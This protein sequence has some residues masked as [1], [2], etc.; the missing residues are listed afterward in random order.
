MLNALRS[1]VERQIA[2]TRAAGGL[3]GLAGEGKPLP[4][5]DPTQ[6]TA[7]ATGLRIMADAGVVPEEIPL[8]KQLHEARQLYATLTDPVEKRAQSALIAD[9]ELRYNTAREARKKFMS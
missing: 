4:Y 6:N 2:K 1:L 8:K 3:T 7:E 9:L 5:R